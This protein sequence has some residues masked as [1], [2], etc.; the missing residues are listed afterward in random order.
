MPVIEPNPGG[1][2]LH[3]A[4]TL[5]AAG[6]GLTGDLT[7]AGKSIGFAIGGGLGTLGSG[8][9]IV[10]VIVIAIGKAIEATA[11]RLDVRDELSVLQRLRFA[12][13]PHRSRVLPRPRPPACRPLSSS[14]D[15]L[16]ADK[17]MTRPRP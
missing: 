13:T 17:R 4:I 8:I 6:G 11:R 1:T 12:L 9:V 10:I 15:R 3:H 14:P 7:R 16:H 5:L 2:A